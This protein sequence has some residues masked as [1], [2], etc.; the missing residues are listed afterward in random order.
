MRH[1]HASLSPEESRTG[2]RLAGYDVRVRWALGLTA[3]LAV[4]A[5]NRI[6]FG[7]LAWTGSLIVLAAARTPLRVVVHRLIGPLSLAAVVFLARTFLTGTTP[8]AEV[9]LGFCRLTA[10]R[11]GLLGGT[12]IASRVLGALGVAAVLCRNT[13]I[14]ELSA[15]LHWARVPGVWIE[16]ALLMHRYLHVFSDQAVRVVSAQKVRLG[17]SG[18]RQSFRSAGSLA[19]MVILHS[20][21]QAE[22]S[23]EAMVARGYRGFLPLP[24]LPSLSRRQTAIICVGAAMIVAAYALAERWPP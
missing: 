7:L 2:D 24:L 21:D 3:I 22:K 12:L 11:E 14:Q 15:T 18:C 5:S 16:I 19:G 6:A 4:A 23:H 13:S 17:Y 9:D 1:V 10:T 20:L 8:V